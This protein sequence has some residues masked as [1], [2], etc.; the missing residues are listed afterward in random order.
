MRTKSW[1]RAVWT[2]HGAPALSGLGSELTLELEGREKLID[3]GGNDFVYTTVRANELAVLDARPPSDDATEST[4]TILK[5]SADALQP[6]IVA[7]PGQP[8]SGVAGWA[9]VMDATR[10]TAI[11]LTDFAR[12]AHD[13]IEVGGDGRLLLWRT[14]NGR[15]EE[16]TVFEF[17]IHF[18]GMPVHIGARTSP[19]SMRSPLRVE[20]QSN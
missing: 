9:H 3:F 19:Q 14:L 6:H 2:L 20:W 15:Q 1:V 13:R 7:P 16:R 10:C 18:V 4:W 11:S 17:A 8:Q 12:A 5:G